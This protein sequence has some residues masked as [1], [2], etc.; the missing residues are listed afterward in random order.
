ML[1]NKIKISKRNIKLLVVLIIIFG[2]F[3]LINV[4]INDII[5]SQNEYMENGG[6]ISSVGYIRETSEKSGEIGEA[7]FGHSVEEKIIEREIPLKERDFE[8]LL[9]G[10]YITTETLREGF[11]VQGIIE[12]VG[13]YDGTVYMKNPGGYY[14]AI[15]YKIDEDKYVVLFFE[16]GLPHFR[17]LKSIAVWNEEGK[18]QRDINIGEVEIPERKRDI[19]IDGYWPQDMDDYE[20]LPKRFG[21][22]I[23]ENIKERNTPLKESDFEQL[24]VGQYFTWGGDPERAVYSLKIVE[25][26]GAC[27]GFLMIHP[28]S[29]GTGM[30]GSAMPYY[31]IDDNTYVILFFLANSIRGP[32]THIEV[33][34]AEGNK[35]RNIEIIKGIFEEI[36]IELYYLR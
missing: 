25:V 3:I 22:V 17:Q 10:Q 18:K 2:V 24:G 4:A 12:T 11:E 5:N 30:I 20:N 28:R 15:Y 31:I 1:Q 27:D 33:W 6:V 36:P 29:P 9:K 21:Y 14:M 34:D 32:L 35:L 26:V 23:E 8:K 13:E 19:S 16:D 7:K